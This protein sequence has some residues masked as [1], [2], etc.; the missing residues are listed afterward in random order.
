[1]KKLFLAIEEIPNSSMYGADID[2]LM[3]L[4]S[5]KTTVGELL[6]LNVEDYQSKITLL[7]NKLDDAGGIS[8]NATVQALRKVP[9]IVEWGGFI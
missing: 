1:M 6:A 7:R 4:F 9:A 3:N 2:E 5:G 8:I